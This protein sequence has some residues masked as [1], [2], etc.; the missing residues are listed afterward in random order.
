VDSSA[1]GWVLPG[2]IA[3]LRAPGTPLAAQMQYRFR[4][5]ATAAA[6]RADVAAVT[7]ALPA[8]AVTGSQSYLAVRAQ[9][10]SN[11]AP[12]V[13]FVL[14][15]AVLGLALSAL[16]VANVISGAVVAGYR[17]I[18]VLKSI[19]FS[20]GQV[21]AAYTGQAMVPAVAGCLAGVALGNLLAIPVLGQTATVYGVGSLHVPGWVDVAVPLAMCCLTGVSAL[22]P[23]LR[24]GR[25][26]AVQAIAA[27]R[28]PRTGRGY[29]AHRLL[30]RLALPRPVTIGLA[31][32]FARPART[33]I[34]LTAVL[35]G[36]T[37][38]TFAV[39]LGASLNRVADGIN[40][41]GAE[42]VQVFVSPPGRGKAPAPAEAQRAITAALRATPGTLRFVEET[43]HPITVAGL[44]QQVAATAF[45]GDA[46]WTGYPLISGHWYTG[47]G[48]AVVGTGFLT[49]TG[50]SVGDTV[51]IVSGRRL[52]P[53]K[54]VGQVFDTDNNGIV[55]I[56][57]WQTLARTGPGP[58]PGRY[59]VGLRPGTSA[60]TYAQAVGRRL[61]GPYG[62][63]VNAR[64]GF[65]VVIGL[66]GTLTLLLAIVAG[67]GVLNTVVLHTR[68]RV[69]DL[70]VFKAIGMTPRQAIAM[71]VC[72]V[73]GTGLVAGVIAVPAGIALHH[74]V[75]PAM[76]AAAN[77]GLPASFLHVYGGWLVAALGLA[78]LVIA[79]AGA[80]LPA[81]WAAATRTATALRAE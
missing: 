22:L 29:T 70:G 43:G 25:F 9:E 66:I 55:L 58:M 48:E 51:T 59:D 7:A 39:G 52:V 73:A 77:V 41:D 56:T 76:A 69:H 15:F 1:G 80:L 63:A 72:W 75:L 26:S 16:I 18:G 64:D 28:A 24:A 78:G 40:H 27:G 20:P 42:P 5:A 67:L 34:T 60:V 30:G 79:V 10:A 8:G 37:A 14:A 36:A 4:D 23:A 57:D 53:V 47:P 74:Y 21:V 44:S 19:G 50:K 65:T 3:G 68:E 49:D 2:Q 45:R 62:V 17:R 46:R 38:V 35:L 32:P 11:I 13:P 12:F 33:A 6:V 31:A 61:A 81:S 71:V 54:I